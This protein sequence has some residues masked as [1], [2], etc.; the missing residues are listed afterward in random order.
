M[1]YSQ[2][3]EKSERTRQNLPFTCINPLDSGKSTIAAKFYTE[4][5]IRSRSARAGLQF[6]VAR[7]HRLLKKGNLAKHIGSIAAGVFIVIST[8]RGLRACL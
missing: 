7:I 8:L 3:K 4:V 2:A 5:K 6:S 1:I